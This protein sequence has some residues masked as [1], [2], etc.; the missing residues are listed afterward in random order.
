MKTK[1]TTM[2]NKLAGAVQCLAK[3]QLACFVGICI[4]AALVMT[5]V[6]LELYRHSGAIKLD[7]SRPGFERVRRE[8]EKSVDD[9]PLSGSGS[10]DTK[11]IKDFNKRLDNYASDLHSMGNYSST[12]IEDSDLN[13]SAPAAETEPK[14]DENNPTP[15]ATDG[16]PAN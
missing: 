3:Y 16:Q 7:L 10:I 9:Q 6:S 15:P 2:R 8:V 5:V 1:I 12:S 13:L 11:T 4:V 14:P